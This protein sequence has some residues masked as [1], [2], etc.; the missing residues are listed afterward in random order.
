MLSEDELYMVKIFGV[1][2]RDSQA[3][4][5]FEAAQDVDEIGTGDEAS[6]ALAFFRPG[7][8]EVY[9]ETIDGVIGQ[10]IDQEAGGIFTNEADVLEVP[11][12]DAVNGEAVKFACPFNSEEIGIR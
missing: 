11:A 7:V 1:V 8:G 3:A 2:G 12:A 5:R 10:K 6:F 4:F 9:V